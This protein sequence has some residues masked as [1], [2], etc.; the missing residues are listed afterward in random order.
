MKYS[1]LRIDRFFIFVKF[2]DPRS[3]IVY[4]SYVKKNYAFFSVFI[5]CM[6]GTFVMLEVFFNEGP[7]ALHNVCGLYI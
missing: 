4:S 5:L 6:G 3:A 2:D 7:L 1:S